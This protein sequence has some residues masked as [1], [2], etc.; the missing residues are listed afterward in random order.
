M[1]ASKRLWR[2]FA[3]GVRSSDPPFPAASASSSRGHSGVERHRAREGGRFAGYSRGLPRF[4]K[5]IRRAVQQYVRQCRI[6]ACRNSSAGT[7]RRA[8]CPRRALHRLPHRATMRRCCAN[9]ACPPAH[10]TASSQSPASR[11][12][13]RASRARSTR[14]SRAYTP[15]RITACACAMA[16][17]SRLAAP[18]WATRARMRRPAASPARMRRPHS[19]RCRGAPRIFGSLLAARWR[20]LFGPADGVPLS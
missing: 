3:A 13:R 11:C 18:A 14:R 16:L 9:P 6:C 1:A 20:E 7:I 19:S 2:I 10:S 12:V 17:H 5:P 4:N 15:P 8:A